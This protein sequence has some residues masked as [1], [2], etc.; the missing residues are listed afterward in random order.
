[1]NKNKVRSRKEIKG[2]GKGRKQAKE[3]RSKDN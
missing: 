2:E 3:E 1:M